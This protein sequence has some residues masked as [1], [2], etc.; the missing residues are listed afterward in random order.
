MEIALSHGVARAAVVAFGVDSIT[1]WLTQA[2]DGA[3]SGRG[4]VVSVTSEFKT[5]K[6]KTESCPG[7]DF[8]TLGF[9]IRRLPGGVIGNTGGFGPPI[10]GSSPGRVDKWF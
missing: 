2:S 7:F 8:S 4:K 9:L 3:K 6:C 10:P 5:K 1:A